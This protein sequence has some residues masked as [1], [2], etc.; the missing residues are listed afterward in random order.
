VPAIPIYPGY[1]LLQN[2][3]G[4]NTFV[5]IQNLF[6]NTYPSFRNSQVLSAQLAENST[7]NNISYRIVYRLANGSIMTVRINYS[8]NS[9]QQVQI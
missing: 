6:K 8:P 2:P 5:T 7:N 4:N 9:Q 1:T 3:T